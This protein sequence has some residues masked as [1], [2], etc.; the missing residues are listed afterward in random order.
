MGAVFG[1]LPSLP[2]EEANRIVVA[3]VFGRLD[4][5]AA[6]PTL[7]DIT[8]DWR[9]DVVVRDPCEFGSLVAA[10]GSGIP[11]VQVAIGLGQFL[12]SVADALDE[13]LRELEQL[14]GLDDLRGA[15]RVLAT[16]TFTSVPA[17][18][19][20]L[21]Q[22]EGGPADG[23]QVWRF[24][25]D[26]SASGPP[27]PAEWGEPTA[28]LVYVSFG[29]VT[30]SVGHFDAVYP[31][32]VE[33]LADLPVRV[34][35]T[36]GSGYDPARLGPLP[37]NT[38]A[39]RWWPQ[40]AAMPEAAVVIGHGGFGTTMTAVAA[41]VPQLVLPLFASDQFLNAER[42]QAAGLGFQLLGGPDAMPEV[43]GLVQQLLDEPRYA[44]AARRIAADMAALP[45][46][47]TTVAVLEEL[48]S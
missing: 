23:S 30:G 6:L 12:L 14:A 37:A 25:T 16:P 21:P 27:L 22:A 2:R 13:P 4:A 44:D 3:E 48:A 20:D 18:L 29:S 43:P 40:A 11:Q 24:R 47:S 1:R 45:D 10:V 41:G 39:T 46:V 8:R 32:V 7:T 42:I 26:T 5:Q 36:T 35:L 15:D 34:L 9:P 38:W 28:P 31:A 17:E 33:A 19:D